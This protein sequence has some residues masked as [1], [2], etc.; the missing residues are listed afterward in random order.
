MAVDAKLIAE[1]RTEFGKGAA[2][3]IRRADRIPAVLYGHGQ[4][5][6]H[7]TLEGHA[8]MMAL[9]TS[10]ALL[11]IENPD[12]T[13]NE[14]AIARE[15]Q[16]HPVTRLI[17]HV[18]LIIV[19]R[20]EKIEVDVP[21]HVEGEAAPGTIVSVDNQTLLVLAE[22]THIPE[23][24]EVSVEGREVGDHIYAADVT[25]PQ[26]TELV[27]DP[28]MLVVNISAELS[29]EQLEAELE[30][31]AVDEE[32][33]ASTGAEPSEDAEDGGDSEGEGEGDEEKSED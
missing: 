28:E 2:R 3:R 15:V 20:G 9:K 22:A 19:K 25:L 16:V 11:E 18:D 1:R 30:S 10:N 27:A 21:V 33:A 17:E 23:Y 8:T 13:K 29:E 31:E 12:A 32:V 7:L 4:D 6:I 26:G 14:L 24:F 5:P